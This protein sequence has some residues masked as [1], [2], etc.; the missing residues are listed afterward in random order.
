[1]PPFP[2]SYSFDKIEISG[3]IHTT[4]KFIKGILDIKSGEPIT[5]DQIE[6]KISILYGS[7]YYKKV[8]YS[9]KN[10]PDGNQILH[11]D[12]IENPPAQLKF[13]IY[14]DNESSGGITANFT[15]RNI[16]LKN[17]R[18]IID[19]FI[20][21]DMQL[22]INYLKYLDRRQRLYLFIA[23]EY[24]KD[25][26]FRTKNFLN[27]D[28]T[29]LY[30]MFNSGLGIAFNF[31]QNISIGTAWQYRNAWAKPD[32]NADPVINKIRHQDFPADLFFA[33]NTVN[34]AYF[35]TDGLRTGIDV[36]YHVHPMQHA[37]LTAD[38]QDDQEAADAATNVNPYWIFKWWLEK[39]FK[40]SKKATIYTAGSIYLSSH[41]DTAF[42]DQQFIGGVVPIFSN[43]V[44]FIGSN[45]SAYM[46]DQLARLALGVQF[47]LVSNLYIKFTANYFNFNYP[48]VWLNPN[49]KKNYFED[50]GHQLDSNLGGG[51]EIAYASKIGPIRLVVHQD[52]YSKK[53]NFFIG[54]GYPFRNIFPSF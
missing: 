12:V 35:P 17:S 20:S 44:Q 22:Q 25:S 24:S 53:P 21:Q 8:T 1:V 32:V 14:Y 36:S 18:L 10:F 31:N 33:V 48:A 43:S 34:K 2:D 5:A 13:G 50:G 26:E 38:Y 3:T 27:E 7:S 46:S 28:A 42:N 11:I 30:R 37:S 49:L 47:M 15:L 39:Y 9:M 19:T 52:V 40:V 4:E 6:E 29:Y 51:V 23:G 16:A 45:K 54:I 41:N